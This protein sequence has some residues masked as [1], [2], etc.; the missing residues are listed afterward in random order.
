MCNRHQKGSSGAV[1]ETV[2][3][4]AGS[5]NIF[6][7]PNERQIHGQV[8]PAPEGDSQRDASANLPIQSLAGQAPVPAFPACSCRPRSLNSWRVK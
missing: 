2:S 6:L 1:L 4:A 3:L 8:G 5:R 7:K